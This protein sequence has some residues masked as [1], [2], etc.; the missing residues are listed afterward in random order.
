M[1]GIYQDSFKQYL[2]DNLGKVKTS[3]KNFI[4]PCPW[5]EYQQDK[6]HYHLYIALEAPIFHCFHASCGMGGNLRKLLR[7]IAGHDISDVFVDKKTME[8]ARRKA[9]VFKD[10]DSSKIVI[11]T[12]TLNKNQFAHKEFYLRNRLKFSNIPSEMITG[13]VYDIEKFIEINNIPVDVSLFRLKDYLQGNFIGFLTE[14]NSALMLRNIDN[15]H[16][17]KFHKLKIQESNFLDYYKLQGYSWKSNKVVLAEGIFDIFVE[18]IFDTTSLKNDVKLYA[19]ALSSKYASL[20][21]SIVFHEQIFRPDI[22]ILSDQGLYLNEY[23]KLKRYND[24]I[25][26]S[27]TVYYNKSGKDFGETRVAPVKYIV[28]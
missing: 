9:E 23:K 10:K 18:H 17:M 22:V 15:S 16:E 27:L 11:R 12:P 25:I 6:D 20:I 4:V 8:E 1:I 26:N 28:K 3:S 13:L 14:N 7:K 2:E 24:H 5:C 19:S 21:K